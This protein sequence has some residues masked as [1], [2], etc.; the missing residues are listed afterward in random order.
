MILVTSSE[1][2]LK[3]EEIILQK[4]RK[5]FARQDDNELL[6]FILSLLHDQNT[7]LE[8]AK[9]DIIQEKQKALVK[10]EADKLI[11]ETE[12]SGLVK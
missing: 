4:I 8:N 7:V 10:I 6:Q 1:T 3:M 9:Q 12:L 2:W 5:C 11:L